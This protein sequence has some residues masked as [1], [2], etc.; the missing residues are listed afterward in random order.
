MLPDY[1]YNL[2]WSGR[3]VAWYARLL[4]VQEVASSNL[5]AP[6][7]LKIEGRWCMRA[8]PPTVLFRKMSGISAKILIWVGLLSISGWVSAAEFF[9]NTLGMVFVKVPAGR[10]IMGN[11]NIEVDPDRCFG[12]LPAHPVT[13][14]KDFYI[15]ITEVTLEQF[16]RFKPRFEG[17]TNLLP[18]V[19]G[20]SWHEAMEFCEWLSQ[21]EGRSYRLPTEAEWEYAAWNA[22]ELGIS[23]VTTDP[24][25]WCLDWYELYEGGHAVDPVGRM[26]GL[27]KV[28]RGGRL[29]D[30]SKRDSQAFYAHI[31]HRSSIAP[32]FGTDQVGRFGKHRI[33]FRVVLGDLPRGRLTPPPANFAFAGVKQNTNLA[34]I[35]PQK[36]YFRKRY[37]L[38]VPLDNSERQA[39]ITSGFPPFYRGHN[40]SPALTV[41]PNGDVLAVFYTSYTE[42]ESEVSM[43]ISRLRF[44]ADD[45]DFPEPFIDFA[46]AN[47]HA[48]LL[49]TDGPK[50]WFFWGSPELTSAYPFQWI[51]S[52][53]NGVTWSPVRFPKFIGEVGPH[54]RQPINTAFRGI[55]GTI[56]LA[57]D[58]Q[59]RTS[60]LWATTNDGVTWFD[61]GGRSAGR[62]TAY[63]QR[64]DGTLLGFGGKNTHID[65]YMPL[66]ISKDGGKTWKVEKSSFPAL[67]NNQRPCV[68]RLQSGKIL[69]VGDFQ[70]YRGNRPPG[71]TNVGCFVAISADEGET[72]RI[73]PIPGA[74]P[75]E[76][77]GRLAGAP[78]LG[79]CVVRQAPNGMIHLI[80]SM[81]H[82]CLHF[83]F[84]EA[85][86]F[87][88]EPSPPPDDVLLKS[89]ATNII[90]STKY[91]E[92]DGV[93]RVINEFEG[94]IANDGRW[95]YH[96]KVVGYYANG[97][98]QWEAEFD[99]G[100]RVGVERFY[101]PNGGKVWEKIYVTKERWKW[102]QYWPNGRI[103]SISHWN[104]FF[105]DGPA[106]QF[107]PDGKL[108]REGWFENGNLVRLEI[109]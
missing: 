102:I 104:G 64:K 33:G 14:T 77:P 92:R 38:P 63:V 96:G 10:F 59:G 103:K 19:A 56:Y 54:D 41:C 82:P 27:T 11:T 67:G 47:D 79:Y 5:A 34:I 60:V 87:S 21:L 48:P 25:E 76:R 12:E 78:T 71:I 66:A 72:W 100:K 46:G 106:M 4:G 44:G 26:S 15:G 13:I 3:S 55:D 68:I 1:S 90:R 97:R 101:A 49:F 109:R 98:K 84:N 89:G 16:R 37:L 83:E 52:L 6:T 18:Y 29:D 94:G 8:S 43:I 23:N 20:V 36:P 88:D 65:G 91:V 57:S 22:M 80:T 50:I 28:V 74:Q 24:L 85:W 93:G 2:G 51:E 81:N 39:I 75:H 7:I 32:S 95:L 69:Y 99:L 62:H 70:D 105:C 86:I 73:K 40:H 35:G 45:W 108:V 53:D 17:N 31:T 107:A 58:G 9:T 30:T 42:Y 61:T